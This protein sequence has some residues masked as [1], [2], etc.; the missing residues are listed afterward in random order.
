MIEVLSVYL[1]PGALVLC[2]EAEIFNNIKAFNQFEKHFTDELIS[3]RVVF[4]QLV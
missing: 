3:G 4:D 1:H 2:I